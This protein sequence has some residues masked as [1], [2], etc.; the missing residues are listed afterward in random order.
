[1]LKLMRERELGLDK[2]RYCT[3]IRARRRDEPFGF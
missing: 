1:M 3:I 2:S